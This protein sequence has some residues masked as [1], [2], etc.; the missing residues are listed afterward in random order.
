MKIP[1]RMFVVAVLSL[2]AVCA[3]VGLLP[4]W[5]VERDDRTVAVIADFRE[6]LPLARAAGMSADEALDMLKERGLRGLM[7]SEL[8]GGDALHGVGPAT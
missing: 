3:A 6:V 4:R 5:K 8:T 7:V 2:A 1:T